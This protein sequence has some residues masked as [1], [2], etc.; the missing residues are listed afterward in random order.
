MGHSYNEF[1][2]VVPNTQQSRNPGHPAILG[3]P[4]NKWDEVHSTSGSFD[5]ITVS[6]LP[7]QS[8]DDS[9]VKAII[10]S[11]IQSIVIMH[12]L[13][14]EFVD[15]QV[16]DESKQIVQPNANTIIV[17]QPAPGVQNQLMEQS[18]EIPD[19]FGVGSGVVSIHLERRGAHTQD[20]YLGTVRVIGIGMKRNRIPKP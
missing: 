2:G 4:E 17:N 14:T 12:N 18:F 6:G 11:A 15:V 16:Y 7:V 20:T 1:D 10:P 8:Y 19:I 13:G 9:M 3:F 5:C